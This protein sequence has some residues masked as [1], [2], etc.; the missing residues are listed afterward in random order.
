MAKGKN[1][2][3]T[4]VDNA[5]D[6]ILNDE[7]K[8]VK[9]ENNIGEEPKVEEQQGGDNTQESDIDRD[10][11]DFKNSSSE[12]EFP[13]QEE[14]KPKEEPTTTSF[15]MVDNFKLR[16][17]LGLFFLLLD[18]VHSFIFRFVTK[19]DVRKADIAFDEDDKEAVMVYFNSPRVM[20]FINQMPA[21]LIGF[22]H[23]EYIYITKLQEA[24][25]EKRLKLKKST[26]QNE[27]EEE[28]EEEEDTPKKA[29]AKKRPARRKP[30]RKAPTKAKK[31]EKLEEE[32]KA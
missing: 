28:E 26:K 27:E 31:E 10:F 5:G 30:K 4:L 19:Y 17:F 9:Q 7:T 2:E 12:H 14:N 13:E 15:D 24:I 1:D 18:S 16:M 25:E 32:V 23:V 29:P 3:S 21:E 8:G 22:M 11:E 6:E 20:A